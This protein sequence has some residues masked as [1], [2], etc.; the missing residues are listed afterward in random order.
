MIIGI[1]DGSR[2]LSDPWTGFTHFTLLEE[3]PPDGWPGRWGPQGMSVTGGG[4]LRGS[5]TC[6]CVT[7]TL[8]E[9]AHAGGEG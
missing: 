3:K 2:D 5:R 8:E 7:I 1:S 6:V 9:V 4:G